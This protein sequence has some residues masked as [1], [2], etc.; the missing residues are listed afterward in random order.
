LFAPAAY[1]GENVAMKKQFQSS[2]GRMTVMIRI[3]VL[4]AVVCLSDLTGQ[5]ASSG[6][7]DS[8][9]AADLRWMATEPLVDPLDRRV[10]REALPG[11][12][13]GGAVVPYQSAAAL[14][15]A[16]V[17]RSLRGRFRSY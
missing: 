15:G 6:S 8:L 12:R 9:G 2:M 10:A 3:A 7:Q 5:F 14:A 13:F 1:D 11:R 17:A 4:M 16:T